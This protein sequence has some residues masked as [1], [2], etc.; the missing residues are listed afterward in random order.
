M[1]VSTESSIG[2]MA[3]FGCGSLMEVVMSP[4]L[5]PGSDNYKMPAF[6]N[7]KSS[8]QTDGEWLT[9]GTKLI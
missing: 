6:C 1:T 9:S 3:F 4:A 7:I 2:V 8:G 5:M